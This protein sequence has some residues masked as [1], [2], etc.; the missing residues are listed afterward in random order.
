MSF[1]RYNLE[2]FATLGNSSMSLDH[3]GEKKYLQTWQAFEM[4]IEKQDATRRSVGQTLWKYTE[5]NRKAVSHIL[6]FLRCV[7]LQHF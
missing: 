2:W 4:S 5:I 1:A 6:D 7:I 3:C